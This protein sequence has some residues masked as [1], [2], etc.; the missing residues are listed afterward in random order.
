MKDLDSQIKGPRRQRGGVGLVLGSAVLA[1]VLAGSLVA[2]ALASSGSG[3]VSSASS[4]RLGKILVDAKGRTLYALS[5]E[6]TRHLLCKTS[7][8]FKFWPPFMVS[9]SKTKLSAGG[10]V[11]GSLALL[12]RG[13]GVLQVTLN[14]EPLYYYSGDHKSGQVNGEDIHS[15]GGTWHVI[16][17]GSAKKSSASSSGAPATSSGGGSGSQGW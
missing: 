3:V 12:S 17:V 11:Q 14:G 1:L 5:P 10:G 6:T 16:S 7:E 13:K 15:F 4:S 8:C 9:S 2:M